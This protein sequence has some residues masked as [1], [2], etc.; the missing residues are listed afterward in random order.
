MS[1]QMVIIWN[2]TDTTFIYGYFVWMLD[3]SALGQFGPGTFRPEIF[4]PKRQFSRS[5]NSTKYT[6]KQNM[7]TAVKAI[8]DTFLLIAFSAVLMSA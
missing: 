6:L 3:I 7:N 8:F 2:P 4:W 1:Y 5:Y